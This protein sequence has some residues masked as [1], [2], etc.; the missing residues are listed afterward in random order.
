MAGIK[1]TDPGIEVALPIVPML[2]M[3]FQLLFFF[4]ITFNPGKL[5]GQMT[6]NLPATGE[7]KA[8]DQSQVQMSDK[9]DVELEIPSD[10]VVA[11]KSYESNL[12]LTVRDS[13][14]VY[15][16]GKIEGLDRKTRD[17]QHKAIED[18]MGK[19]TAMLKEK[20]EEKKKD[21]PGKAADNVKIEANSAMRYSTLVAVMDACLK[22]GYQ[23]VGFAPPPDAAQ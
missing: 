5:D 23:Q 12:T 11:V 3:S 8:K 7:A 10:F 18:L 1:K 6:M 13:E 16:V 20:L 4:I 9:S 22:A 2:D 14:K 15:E 17:D 19:L 21:N